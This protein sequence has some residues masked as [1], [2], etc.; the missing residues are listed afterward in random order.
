VRGQDYHTGIVLK[1]AQEYYKPLVACKVARRYVF[2][3][4]PTRE[5]RSMSPF[6]LLDRNTSASSKSKTHLH[7]RA[8]LQNSFKFP[9]SSLGEVPRSPQVIGRSGRFNWAA[10]HSAVVVLPTPGGPWRRIIKP[11]PFPWTMSI[12]NCAA[13]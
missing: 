9:S 1:H 6:S 8:K 7:L 10:T 2:P 5:L 13:S 4:P 3:L 11:S 12:V